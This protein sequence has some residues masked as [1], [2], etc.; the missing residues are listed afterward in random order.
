MRSRW[1]SFSKRNFKELLRDPLSYI[2]CLG[3]PLVMLAVMTLVDKSIPAEAA[4]SIFKIDKLSGGI[5]V[6]GHTFLMLFSVLTVS[7]D[8][9][10]A[11]LNRMYAS[12]MCAFDFI[13]GYIF[14][15][16][17]LGLGQTLCTVA[18]ALIISLFT[19]VSFKLSGI[20]F[21]FVGMLP[22]L[23]LFIGIGMLFGTLFNEKAAPGICSIIIS[24]ASF[25]GGI[26]FDVDS[27]GGVMNKLCKCLPFYYCT[28]G[29]RAALASDFSC[30]GLLVPLALTSLCAVIVTA[31]AVFVF[32]RKMKADLS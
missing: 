15:M 12:P 19:D 26:W 2:F 21:V 14:P 8:R 31:L 22:S 10:K 5:I 1:F 9:G 32:K 18:G 6:F 23:F 20:L 7:K 17:V 11:F 28:K 29:V 4:V 30:E 13:L 16:I 24:L 3:F 27:V 25:L